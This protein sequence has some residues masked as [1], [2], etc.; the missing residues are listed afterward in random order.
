MS[1]TRPR[2]SRLTHGVSQTTGERRFLRQTT[3][4]SSQTTPES[5]FSAAFR[6][7]VRPLTPIS[8][9]GPCRVASRPHGRDYAAQQRRRAVRQSRPGFRALRGR[10]GPR[11]RV[12]RPR[13]QLPPERPPGRLPLQGPHAVVADAL[14]RHALGPAP[15]MA[16]LWRSVRAQRRPHRAAHLR[17]AGRAQRGI[18]CPP[19]T[20]PATSATHSPTTANGRSTGSCCSSSGGAAACPATPRWRARPSSSSSTPDRPATAWRPPP[21]RHW[22]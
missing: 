9:Q 7:F 5:P 11:G 21:A 4:Q 12:H 17:D 13:A 1:T 20:R 8:S 19:R 16:A 14:G 10:E 22:R 3:H 6:A 2:I 18:P 15:A